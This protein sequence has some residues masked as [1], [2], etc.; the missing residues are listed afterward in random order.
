MK[1]ASDMNTCSGLDVQGSDRDFLADAFGPAP[2]SPTIALPGRLGDGAPGFSGDRLL[3]ILDRAP[4]LIAVTRGPGH[5]LEFAN[6]TCRDLLGSAC[7][8][9]RPLSIED[10]VL[11]G[12][13]LLQRLDGAFA[14]TPGQPGPAVELRGQGGDPSLPLFL[15]FVIQPVIAAQGQVSGLLIEGHEV[16][17]RV[18]AKRR[19]ALFIDEMNHRVKNSLA[20]V[21]ALIR[22]TR[23]TA[24]SLDAFTDSLSRRIVAMG[25]TQALIT[26][27]ALD[28]VGV[29]DLLALELAPY[30]GEGGPVELACADFEV[31]S[32]SAV[33]LSLIIHELLT[34]AAKYGALAEPG[35][36]LR[37][38][39]APHPDGG[40]ALTWRETTVQPLAPAGPPGFG[41]ALIARLARGLGGGIDLTW[42][43]DG[44]DVLIRFKAR[45]GGPAAL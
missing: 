32:L 34:N 39:C 26:T 42:R 1:M 29:Q 2:S 18:L 16:T 31:T 38:A 41:T 11:A 8:L 6:R 9:G 14:Q 27:T 12:G 15:D 40:A 19:Q 17:D 10:G 24:A 36:Q 20:T 23:Q 35:G 22:L 43:P 3:A 45:P 21:L 33:N 28:A 7:V 30:L 13:D 4:C 25:K 37:V 44:L 5:I